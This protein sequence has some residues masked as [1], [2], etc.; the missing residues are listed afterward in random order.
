MKA[1]DLQTVPIDELRAFLHGAHADPFRILGPHRVGNDLVVRVFRPDA[2]AVSI[3][4]DDGGESFVA[5]KL[6]AEGL[7]QATLP[8]RNRD[9]RYSVEIERWDDSK[10]SVRD[11]YS[12]GVIMG[13]I[14]LHL[15]AE[16]QH[17]E[18]YD[19]FGAHLREIGGDRGVYFAVW[20]PNAQRV[21]VVGDFN[22]WDGRVHP[23][24]R[25]LGSGAWELFVPGIGEGTHYKFEIRTPNGAVFLKSDPFAFFNQH[26]RATS[27]L[28]FDLKRYR[29]ND[30]A[31]MEARRTRDWP[32]SAVSIYEV[33]LGSW[34]RKAEEGNRQLSYRELADTLL[35][36]VLEM[37]YTH[38]ELMPIAEHPFEG[39][40]GYQVTNYFAPT[41]RFGNPDEFRYF[42]DRCHQ[43]GIGVI[44]DWVPAH[45]PKDAHGL[46]EFDGT[47]LYEH[48]DP[49]QGEHA[50]WGTLIFNFGRNEVRNFLIANALF[51]LDQYHVDGLRVDAVAS[52]LYLDYS[53]KAGEWIP[54]QFGGRENLDAVYFLKRCNEVCYE[55]HPGIM[56]IAEESTAWPG[57]SRPTYLGGLGFGLK[58]N[59]GW[60]HDFLDYMQLDP[61]YR[62]FHQGNITFSLIY[63]FQ[64]NFV[65]VLSHDEVVYGKCSMLGKMPGDEWQKFA[66]LRMFY[67]WMY[68]HP[69]KKLLFMGGEFGQWAEW[70][71]DA[72]LDW[73][74]LALPRH[75]GL[76]RLVQH[77]NFLY[78][79]EPALWSLDDTYDGF[80][81]ID[82][83]DAD[84]SVV[85]WLRK[86]S[87]GE[88]IVFL[89]N[90][91]PVVH[92]GYH[93]GAPK[94][95]YYREI[96]NTDAETYGGSNV[97]NLGGITA[98]PEPWQG[99][100]HSLFVNLPPLACV[101][102]KWEGERIAAILSR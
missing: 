2:R 47:D 96:I 9:A 97:G 101:A 42:V 43:A 23:M 62:R 4:L 60:M 5:E 82:F 91:T 72:Q 93:I 53:R 48:A 100:E 24:R 89:V 79:N 85:A 68:G 34:R 69:G 45:F 102:L 83:H 55:R 39:S 84:N 16:G 38:L 40:W 37:G 13:E 10:F 31:W 11:P 88:I 17:W 56:T 20:A 35:P 22:G 19:K 80:E 14:D 1:F 7:F 78:R 29:W 46:A 49:R 6:D 67:A 94:G 87:E 64:E 32:R 25:L 57:V 18:L 63:A 61:I 54:N 90:A 74:L 30:A 41:S 27:S 92:Y 26:G 71:H 44:V 52:M 95:G 70:N 66:N 8:D 65:L 28:V 81:W 59:M 33:H 86:S 50:D 99:R 75:D 15:F 98:T 76:R 51:W 3:K 12:Y 36:Y 77:L 73:P 21:S 58:W